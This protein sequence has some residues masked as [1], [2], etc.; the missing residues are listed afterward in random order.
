M[1]TS[2]N[3]AGQGA[4]AMSEAGLSKEGAFG[5]GG[6]V[7]KT[8]RIWGRNL[9][10]FAAISLLFQSP[11]IVGSFFL[12]A[13]PIAQVD[14]NALLRNI[15]TLVSTVMSFA[16]AGALTYGVLGALRGRPASFAALFEFGVKNLGRI[17]VVSFGV[18]FFTLLAALLLVVPGVI[19]GLMLAVAVPA[20]VAEPQLSHGDA[21]RR[22]RTLTKGH[23]L[24]LFLALLVVYA[25]VA[26]PVIP[27]ST[28]AVLVPALQG[29]VAYG[30]ITIVS[31]VL[32]SL[33]S[34]CQAVAY[35]D[36]RVAKE[37]VGT[38]ALA[39]VFD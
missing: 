3:G 19:V 16:A 20:A 31:A 4:S 7:G 9:L 37:G 27:L 5:V 17:L 28:A 1:E 13:P 11:L 8:F 22:S 33:F 34:T 29:G 15:L 26:I 12:G 23:R 2:A 32:G 6:V 24:S 25:V 36:L 39:A 35:H 30:A 14:P 38:E 21:L 10:A 18:G